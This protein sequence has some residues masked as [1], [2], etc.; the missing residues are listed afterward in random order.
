MYYKIDAIDSWFFRNPAPFDASFNSY[1]ESIFPPYPSVYAGALQNCAVAIPNPERKVDNFT[2]ALRIG[3]NGIMTDKHILFPLPLDLY[4]TKNKE[5]DENKKEDSMYTAQIMQL[6]YSSGSSHPL[7]YFLT[8]KERDKNNKPL[9]IAGGGYF[10]EETMNSYLKGDNQEYKVVSLENYI[11]KE[12][13]IGIGINSST[14]TIEKGMFYQ[15]NVIVPKKI[16]VEIYE[17]EISKEKKI[18]YQLKQC[19]LALEASGIEMPEKTAIVRLGGEGRLGKVTQIEK[20]LPIP[21]AP[22]NKLAGDDYFKLYLATPAIFEKGWLPGWINKEAGEKWIGKFTYKKHSVRMELIS[23]A[24]ERPVAVGGFRFNRPS[25]LRYAVPAGSVYFF[26]LLDGKMED[27]IRLFH[28]KCI[29][30]YRGSDDLSRERFFDKKRDRYRY[31]SR[32][33]G[34]CLVGSIS[35]VQ[36]GEINDVR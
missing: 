25:E 22:E 23:A 35:K 13:H 14:G 3:W 16:S 30:D 17:D 24:V 19:S 34:Y 5:K 9:H 11:S 26:K 27:V 21:V 2:R 15:Q 8:F 29:S 18:K 20:D 7:R 31:C 4:I 36:K 1:G 6:A 28:K 33:F 32:G 10:D 12:A